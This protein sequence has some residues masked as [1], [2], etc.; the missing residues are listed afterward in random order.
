MPGCVC[1]I[2]LGAGSPST[3]RQAVDSAQKVAQSP[4]AVRPPGAHRASLSFCVGE[5]VCHRAVLVTPVPAFSD[6]LSAPEVRTQGNKKNHL[7]AARLRVVRIY[8]AAAHPPHARGF[9]PAMV[10]FPPPASTFPKPPLSG[11]E[12]HTPTQ[13]GHLGALADARRA[14]QVSQG[15]SRCSRDSAGQDRRAE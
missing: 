5:T 3:S 7:C 4:A 1:L 6:I 13:A 9:V 8:R 10:R 12:P 15:F 14:A 2:I 11:R